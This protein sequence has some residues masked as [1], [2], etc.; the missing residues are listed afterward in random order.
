MGSVLVKQK[1]DLVYGASNV[2]LMG[3]LA[4]SVLEQGGKA[5]GVIPE[6]LYRQVEHVELTELHIVNNMHE[7][8]ALMFELADAFIALPGGIGTLEEFF[9]MFTWL[10]LGIHQKPVGILNVAGFYDHLFVFLDHLVQEG[11]LKEGHRNNLV[12]S[13]DAADLIEKLKT[14][15]LYNEKKWI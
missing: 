9:E 10:Q 5:I 2:G 3:K 7:R 15:S 13:A 8:K 6:T 4:R 14:V 12:V 1:I 11:F